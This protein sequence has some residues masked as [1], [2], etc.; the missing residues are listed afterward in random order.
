MI[1]STS[2]RTRA[3]RAPTNTRSRSRAP[4]NI[5]SR[6]RAP[7]CN[8]AAPRRRPLGL[9]LGLTPAQQRRGR[10]RRCVADS[11]TRSEG[12][13]RVRHSRPSAL[14]RQRTRRRRTRRPHWPRP[15]KSA[16]LPW[17]AKKPAVAQRTA[18]MRQVR[19]RQAPKRQVLK[20]LVRQRQVPKRRVLRRQVPKRQVLQQTVPKRQVLQQTVPKRAVRKLAAL[21]AAALQWLRAARVAAK[22]RRSA[23]GWAARLSW[24]NQR[25]GGCGARAA[26][27]R[28]TSWAPQVARASSAGGHPIRARSTRGCPTSAVAASQAGRGT[29]PP[30][31]GH[32]RRQTRQI[33]L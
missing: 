20:R 17:T 12:P 33:P 11:M 29:T 3:R 30:A 22:R 14:A 9:G 31:H 8:P 15:L 21:R 32:S 24:P 2:A 5:R 13:H 1:R 27:R 4:K 26:R 16:A 19:K 6:S 7:S 25:C 10:L 23:A 28:R 18:R